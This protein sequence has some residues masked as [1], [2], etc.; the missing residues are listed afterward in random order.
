VVFSGKKVLVTG[1]SRGIGFATVEL[2]HSQ[3]AMI[4][5]NG[6]SDA[7]TETAVA[8]LGG[9][10]RLCGVVGDVATAAGCK[11]LVGTAVERLGGLDV[12]V[13]SAGVFAERRIEDTDEAFW[14]QTID[15]NLK[16]PFF[17][18]RAALP[19][20]RQSRG[21][22]VT[23]ASDAGLFGTAEITAY[24]AS[25]GGVVNL[26]RALALEVAPEVRVNCVCPAYVDTDMARRDLIDTADD[27]A[28]KE[29]EMI[30]YAPLKRIC[31]PREAGHA[32]A[33]LA[34]DEA[35]NITGAALQIDGG[36]SSGR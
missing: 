31:T 32:I 21:N 27:P 30:D 23:V 34:C 28:T 7:T 36:S 9:G 18:A 3:G 33:Y 13:N 2:L 6:R 19:A 10:D 35:R 14:D 4:A 8:K 24:C 5:I 15:I 17:C 26:T 20:L 25:K 11:A 16:G 12:L 1:G 22:I 29:R